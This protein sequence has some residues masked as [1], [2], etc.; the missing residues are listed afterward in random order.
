M[1]T[2]HL[3]YSRQPNES[4]SKFF[5]RMSQEVEK[6]EKQEDCSVSDLLFSLP[7][8]AVEKRDLSLTIYYDSQQG[9]YA[10]AKYEIKCKGD[11]SRE[12]TSK[13]LELLT[14]WVTNHPNI[15]IYDV[16]TSLYLDQSGDD[17]ARVVIYYDDVDTSNS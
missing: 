14:E 17:L 15:D 5:N 1:D 4:L 13:A 6:L 3:S 7:D 16:T 12:A 9:D 8:K 2:K 11:T 10:M